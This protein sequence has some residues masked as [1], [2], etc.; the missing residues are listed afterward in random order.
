M[1]C[2]ILILGGSEQ[3]NPALPEEY[4]AETVDPASPTY[5]EFLQATHSWERAAR[6]QHR[7]HPLLLSEHLPTAFGSPDWGAKNPPPT[8]LWWRWKLHNLRQP[9]LGFSLSFFGFLS[10]GYQNH[11]PQDHPRKLYQQI[12]FQTIA[13]NAMYVYIY[14]WAGYNR[15]KK[16]GF[17]L[18][19]PVCTLISLWKAWYEN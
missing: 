18:W 13:Q 8:G 5:Q 3:P 19:N 14:D 6:S 7:T 16:K 1:H 17:W 9:S 4:A 11:F 2:V 15:P 10:S 12:E